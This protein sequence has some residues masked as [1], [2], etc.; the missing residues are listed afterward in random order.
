MAFVLV[1][2]ARRAIAPLAI[3]AMLLGAAVALAAS[4]V[5][6]A[7]YRGTFR[8]GF[9]LPTVTFKVSSNGKKVTNLRATDAGLYCTGG[10]QVTPIKFKDASIS[11]AGKFSSTGTFRLTFGPFKGQIGTRVS[12]TGTFK[13]GGKESGKMKSTLVK[14]PARCSGTSGYSTHVVH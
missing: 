5:K 9:D 14:A 3:V 11:P 1:G 2:S 6:G 4:P 8:A 10:G 13:A 7:K 12:I